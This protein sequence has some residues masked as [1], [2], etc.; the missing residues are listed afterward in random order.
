MKKLL[1][2]F[3]CSVFLVG[4]AQSSKP[5]G[6]KLKE[7]NEENKV[8]ITQTDINEMKDWK[9]YTSKQGFSFQY[10]PIFEVDESDLFINLYYKNQAKEN[11]F[12]SFS[13]II[14][15][16]VSDQDGTLKDVNGIKVYTKNM[17]W[18]KD[19]W[20]SRDAEFKINDKNFIASHI[21]STNSIEQV[22]AT[23]LQGKEEAL[24]DKIISTMSVPKVANEFNLSDLKVGMEIAGLKVTAFGPFEA[25]MGPM[26]MDNLKVSFEGAKTVSG[27]Y[28][29]SEGFPASFNLDDASR[30]NF[31]KLIDDV[32]SPDWFAFNDLDADVVAKL[33][34]VGKQATIVIKNYTLQRYPSEVSSTADLVEVK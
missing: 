31:P 12:L 25:K 5:L 23:A 14:K 18:P 21:L 30:Q 9:T 3:L 24:F 15:G 33:G 13:K 32:V 26:A 17:P 34:K 1:S 11:V 8:I 20:N 28:G 27:W 4:C 7:L 10:P 29:P 2:V 16:D 19:G 22:D 6:L